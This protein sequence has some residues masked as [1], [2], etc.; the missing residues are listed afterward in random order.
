[1][2][3]TSTLN[4]MPNLVLAPLNFSSSTTPDLILKTFAQYCEYVRTPT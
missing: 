4:S 1:M 2:T 3:L